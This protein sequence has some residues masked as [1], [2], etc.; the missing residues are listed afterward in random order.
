MFSLFSSDWVPPMLSLRERLA[1]RECLR[2]GVAVAGLVTPLSPSYESPRVQDRMAEAMLS[3]MLPTLL[4][5]A[6]PDARPE[7]RLGD[8]GEAMSVD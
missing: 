1:T 7:P 3:L 4:L 2:P 8:V 6:W 5:A